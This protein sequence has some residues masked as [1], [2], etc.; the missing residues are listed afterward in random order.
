ML[1]ASLLAPASSARQP[2]SGSGRGADGDGCGDGDGG[3]GG[4]RGAV[5]F[6]LFSV[7]ICKLNLVTFVTMKRKSSTLS[8]VS[9][10][11]K[12][13][14]AP[15]AQSDSLLQLGT[16][17][18]SLI[19]FFRTRIYQLTMYPLSF[20][21][22]LSVLLDT[23]ARISE[24][25]RLRSVDINMNYRVSI[26]AAKG[27]SDRVVAVR[28]Y[29]DVSIDQ[30]RAC[31]NEFCDYSRFYVYRVMKAHGLYLSNSTGGN[32]SVTHAPR[33]LLA[34]EV[35]QLSGS[36]EIAGKA[37]GHKGS[38]SIKY[39]LRDESGRFASQKSDK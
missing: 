24:I 17:D 28:P 11:T 31:F 9:R 12:S 30:F 23:G 4:R 35:E 33:H 25:L 10:G 5:A 6:C 19:V 13:V 3:A 32:N 37:L 22:M 2:A 16:G 21:I 1:V 36:V 8:S 39:Y 15:P 29:P 14:L 34:R 38:K 26:R 27:S 18:Y 20:R 7:Y